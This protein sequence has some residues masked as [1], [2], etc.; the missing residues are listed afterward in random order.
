MLH[1]GTNLTGRVRQGHDNFGLCIIL[2][3]E[4]DKRFFDCVQ[5]TF[6]IGKKASLPDS[7]QVS[8]VIY[9]S[10]YQR[11]QVSPW[12]CDLRMNFVT[13]PYKWSA[14]KISPCYE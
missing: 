8:D 10:F 9:K 7:N 4:I 5:L 2:L 14:H 3:L 6:G 1:N 11:T 13:I 12:G